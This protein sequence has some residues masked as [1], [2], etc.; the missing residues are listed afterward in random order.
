MLEYVKKC[1]DRYISGKELE[2]VDC[3]LK[4]VIAN[5]RSQRVVRRGTKAL[6]ELAREKG[7]NIF[8]S[9]RAVNSRARFERYGEAGLYP[10]LD[11]G[12]VEK[13]PRKE[14]YRIREQFHQALEQ[15]LAGFCP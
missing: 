7:R 1:K 12:V 10:W 8:M 11:A 5:E 14:A 4:G 13:A 2:Y 9:R 3:I 6:L 15:A